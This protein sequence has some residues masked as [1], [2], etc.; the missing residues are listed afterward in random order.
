[1][2]SLTGTTVSYYSSRESNGRLIIR[3]K[4][5]IMLIFSFHSVGLL[6]SV[7]C[8]LSQHFPSF[9]LSVLHCVVSSVR[10]VVFQ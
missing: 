5:G 7:H 4:L 3:L 10:G 9:L 2:F 6:V 1:M 8:S